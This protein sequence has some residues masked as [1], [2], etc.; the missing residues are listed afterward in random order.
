MLTL[1]WGD[2]MVSITNNRVNIYCTALD[3][4]TAL[5]LLNRCRVSKHM[6]DAISSSKLVFYPVAN[7]KHFIRLKSQGLFHLCPPNHSV[8]TS[9]HTTYAKKS[10]NFMDS[11]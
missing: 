10:F 1:F 7:S 5:Q 11:S 9:K 8:L 2:G 6:H 3:A 4:A